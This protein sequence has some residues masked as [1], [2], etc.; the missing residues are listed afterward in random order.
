[1]YI[2]VYIWTG[3]GRFPS[4]AGSVNQCLILNE[5]TLMVFISPPVK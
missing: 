2:V 1:M 3:L 4:T 5:S